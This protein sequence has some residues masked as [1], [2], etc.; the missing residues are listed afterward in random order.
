MWFNIR[1]TCIPGSS[2]DYL[3]F[4]S[5][6]LVHPQLCWLS[7]V[8]HSSDLNSE[9]RSTYDEWT[10]RANQ[11]QWASILD[12]LDLH[13]HLRAV[14]LANFWS[15]VCAY[16][17][18]FCHVYTSFRS[19]ICFARWRTSTAFFCGC[20]QA[21]ALPPHPT[22]TTFPLNFWGGSSSLVK[23]LPMCLP[24]LC[25][26]YSDSNHCVYT[27]CTQWLRLLWLLSLIN[28]KCLH[29]AQTLPS[30][31]HLHHFLSTSFW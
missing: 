20:Y 28:R 5:L 17:F 8:T 21:Q 3:Q 19:A 11:L 26:Q 10:S 14:F 13:V 25:N 22:T 16:K 23:R 2:A 7:F 4:H 31:I 12:S 24:G 29:F 30:M 15:I 18:I 6:S 9:L 1:T 27:T